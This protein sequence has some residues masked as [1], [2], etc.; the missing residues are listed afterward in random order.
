VDADSRRRA[1]R[2]E[3]LGVEKARFEGELV[4]KRKFNVT[5]SDGVSYRVTDTNCPPVGLQDPPR[6]FKLKHRKSSVQTTE[7]WRGK[8]VLRIED[9]GNGFDV[10]FRDEPGVD[11]RRVRL[12]Y[13]DAGD[14]LLL[15][16]IVDTDTTYFNR[17]EITEAVR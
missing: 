13:S 11:S 10:I 6:V 1:A 2:F 16:R 14:L 8:Q 15:L 4:M 17:V 3:K 5:N 7:I 9:D 12:T